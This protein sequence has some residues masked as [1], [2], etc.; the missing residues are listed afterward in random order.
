MGKIWKLF[1][2]KNNLMFYLII[3]CLKHHVCCTPHLLANPWV[4]WVQNGLLHKWTCTTP[5]DY[6]WQDK[7]KSYSAHWW[8]VYLNLTGANKPG[9]FLATKLILLGPTS[10]ISLWW[11]SAS[12][13]TSHESAPFFLFNQSFVWIYEDGILTVQLV[14]VSWVVYKQLF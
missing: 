8:P 6:K 3:S 10:A 9:P 5:P 13:I 1:L 11:I 7:D 12:L 4:F 14:F 2:N